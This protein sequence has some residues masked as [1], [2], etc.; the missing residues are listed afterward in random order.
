VIAT[1][2]G[3]DESFYAFNAFICGQVNTNGDSY[4]Q[5][6]FG[7]VLYVPTPQCTDPTMLS[8]LSPVINTDSISTQTSTPLCLTASALGEANI[9]IALLP[10]VYV[11][12]FR[13]SIEA[14]SSPH[15][16]DISENPVPTQTF[17][18][19]GTAFITYGLE[20][21][22]NQTGLPIDPTTP[23][24]YVPSLVPATPVIGA[25]VRLDYSPG[26]LP[27]STGLETG[28]ILELSDE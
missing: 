19:V 20:F 16:K 14:N 8:D 3:F 27:P 21:L 23:T 26:G 17:Q 6:T 9:T 25:Y 18:W 13:H 4:P 11:P 15:R 7:C 22:G 2:A 10:C 24:D 1:N 5:T 12:L 28:M